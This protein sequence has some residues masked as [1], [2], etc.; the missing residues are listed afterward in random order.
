MDTITTDDV[1][2]VLS[3]IWTSKHETATRIKQRIGV[4]MKWAIA[5][6]WRETN[7]V[8]TIS[9]AL[10]KRPNQVIH[11]PS[12][13][14]DEV[15]SAIEMIKNSQASLSVKLALEML[16]MTASRSGE[17]RNAKWDEI[18]ADKRIWTIPAERMKQRKVHRVPL[19]SRC[20]EILDEADNLRDKSGLIFPGN[21][22]GKS[23]SDAT[24]SKLVRELG[25]K[26]VPHGFRTSFRTWTGEQTN[27]PNEVCEFSLA[28]VVGNAAERA[29]QRSDLFEKR[30]QL[31]A[32]WAQY[33]TH[34]KA[35][36]IKLNTHQQ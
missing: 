8:I 17:I 7:P 2:E 5:K 35:E 3:P 32:M 14:Y 15:Q 36:V 33:L 24:L 21:V 31:M 9:S 4:I 19:S 18:D 11:H 20:I 25:I 13:P 23:L 26:C 22:K 29:Y 12:I 27:I 34:S 16:I 30:R 6:G 1:L 10:P 28:H